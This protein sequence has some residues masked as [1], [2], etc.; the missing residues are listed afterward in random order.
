M[1]AKR[2]NVAICIR[3]HTMSFTKKREGRFAIFYR[4]PKSN[5]S[6]KAMNPSDE[7][8]IVFNSEL[9]LQCNFKLNK[10]RVW[11][12]K[13]VEIIVVNVISTGNPKNEQS[14]NSQSDQP[15]NAGAKN[16]SREMCKWKIDVSKL[17]GKTS[18]DANLSM[19]NNRALGDVQLNLTVARDT[20]VPIV[21][22]DQNSNEPKT[23]PRKEQKRDSK[24]AKKAAKSPDSNTLKL[25]MKS[26]KTA[27][28]LFKIPSPVP[29]NP[30]EFAHRR[31]QSDI[32]GASLQP[33][34]DIAEICS[35]INSEGMSIINDKPELTTRMVDII[36]NDYSQIIDHHR[37]IHQFL[38]ALIK[39]YNGSF[40][41]K[42]YSYLLGFHLYIELKDTNF[43][44]K[45][46]LSLY[47]SFTQSMDY[48]CMSLSDEYGTRI[49]NGNE[50]EIR[51]AGLEIL[52]RVNKMGSGNLFRFATKG[53]LLSFATLFENRIAAILCDEMEIDYPQ[54]T[55]LLPDCDNE[56]GLI[57]KT[58]PVIDQITS[59]LVAYK[60]M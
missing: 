42:I 18:F 27:Q 39:F 9:K 36:N 46:T 50:E 41:E 56:E 2:E 32:T 45:E 23:L 48:A 5:H 3:V 35:R 12:K 55:A 21:N 7:L 51:E 13:I 25:S 52:R 4:R 30:D 38:F 24:S 59:E 33:N 19:P 60:K 6:T 49:A 15:P 17:Y 8:S 16:V 34:E 43:D 26:H 44:F 53:F 47:D 1:S 54:F 14:P 57:Q 10:D 28:Q 37:V 11:Q 20:S 58:S 31:T 29:A 40:E 22:H